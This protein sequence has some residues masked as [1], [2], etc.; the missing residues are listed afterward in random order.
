MINFPN[1]ST[2][3][4]EGN[5]DL[6]TVQASNLFY[7]C[8]F[9]ISCR[10]IPGYGGWKGDESF[11]HLTSR[12]IPLPITRLNHETIQSVFRSKETIP[13]SPV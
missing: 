6:G 12:Y 4:P 3:A 5:H 9:S 8:F 2:E 11:S 1:T 10:S 7:F 13:F